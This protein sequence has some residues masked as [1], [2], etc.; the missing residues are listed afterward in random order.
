[1]AT[2]KRK[3]TTTLR[4]SPRRRRKALSTTLLILPAAL[5]GAGIASADCG[6][7]FLFPTKGL[8]FHHLDTINITYHSDLASPTL[9]CW[10]GAPGRAT[11]S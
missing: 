4:N 2:A 3:T 1:M 5:I 8:Q 9:L 7:N 6:A 11:L 10:C